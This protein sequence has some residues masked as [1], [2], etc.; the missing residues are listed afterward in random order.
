MVALETTANEVLQCLVGLPWSIA[1]RAASMANF[2][3][4]NISYG[5]Q[6]SV[7]QFSLHLQCP[8]RIEHAG[9]VF[10]GASD[11]WEPAD[12]NEEIDWSTWDYEKD[13]N[14]RDSRLQQ[15]LNGVC[16]AT[17]SSRNETD[18]LVVESVLVDST[19]DVRISLSGDYSLVVFPDGSVG[20][21]WRLLPFPKG[22]HF[23]YSRSE[24]LV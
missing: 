11:L 8:W 23:V 17:G 6:E 20:E 18:I 9:D 13:E 14:L 5:E 19:G 4:G 1:R 24:D 21:Q 12:P 16:S 2:H 15:L 22:E 7:G 3:F 10:V